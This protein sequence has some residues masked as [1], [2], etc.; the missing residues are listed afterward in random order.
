MVGELIKIIDNNFQLDN[1]SKSVFKS[2][3]AAP[4]SIEAPHGISSVRV[5]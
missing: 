1:K 3:N 5:E 4:C 2:R